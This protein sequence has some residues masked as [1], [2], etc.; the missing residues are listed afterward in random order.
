MSAAAVRGADVDPLNETL[1]HDTLAF[2]EAWP[3][4]G[5]APKQSGAV[6]L[7]VKAL[8]ALG[9]VPAAGTANDVMGLCGELGAHQ[10]CV[11]LLDADLAVGTKGELQ[12]K[13]VQALW[14]LKTDQPR[15]MV[16]RITDLLTHVSTQTTAQQEVR[17]TA[18]TEREYVWFHDTRWPTWMDLAWA[19]EAGEGTAPGTFVIGFGQGAMEHFLADRPVGD[20]PW[21]DFTAGADTEAE[22]QGVAHGGNL[23]ARVYVSP[24]KF[25]QRFADPMKRTSLGRLFAAWEIGGTENSML[26]VRQRGREL[27]IFSAQPQ[28]NKVV[29]V[30]W[31][32]SLPGAAP[33]LR[34]LPEDATAY[35]VFNVQWAL[36][37]QRTM[38]IA[39]ATFIDPGEPPVETQAADLAQKAGVD[40][41]AD[42]LDRLQPYVLV[43][44][45]PRHPLDVPLMVTT[46]AAARPGSETKVRT[47]LA[48]LTDTIA[49]AVDA[50]KAPVRVRTD[51]DGVSFLQFGLVGPAWGWID[52]A[53]ATSWSPGALKMNRPSAAKVTSAAFAPDRP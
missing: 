17:K 24:H 26:S 31:T 6:A 4:P 12:C 28:Q 51:S 16:E 23:Q 18:E 22:K 49:K 35:A 9:I 40:I 34:A 32:V 19:Y 39:D 15:E 20:V 45:S 50:H 36:L 21:K 52:D 38:A 43:H 27:A 30:P 33:L 47:A 7:G 2:A 11:A 42:I 14:I 44:D 37:Y 3:G 1:P 48:G 46:L 10:S 53:L 41:R 25:E 13:S 5:N 29:V 8:A